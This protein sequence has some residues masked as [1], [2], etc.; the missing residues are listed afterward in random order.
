MIALYITLG[1][2]GFILLADV[3]VAWYFILKYLWRSR[4]FDERERILSYGEDYAEAS[5]MM[6]EGLDWL[7][8]QTLE[9]V[10]TTS[11]DGLRLYGY[12]LRA[13]VQSNKYAICVHGY[14]SSPRMDYGSSIRFL[15]DCGCNVLI[16]DNRSHGRS[17][18]HFCGFSYLDSRDCISWCQYI[19]S[20]FGADSKILLIGISMGGATVLAAS[21]DSKLPSCVRGVVSDCAFSSGWDEL[22]YQMKRQFNLP[23]FPILHTVDLMLRIFARYSLRKGTAAER[24]GNI[25][26]PLLIIHGRADN[27]VPTRM[28]SEI[29]EAASCDKRLLL[30]D[31]A[32]HGIS[33][34]VAPELYR[35]AIR[36]ILV[37]ADMTADEN[38]EEYSGGQKTTDQNFA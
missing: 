31:G 17:E 22:A 15:H 6:C 13:D 34:C 2:I 37:R 7:D 28:A 16:P 24:A 35:E 32:K 14:H 20:H 25:R 36:D 5:R 18:G 27:F 29:Y 1:V 12:L 10:H 30:V 9:D 3:A 19:E 4:P 38:K 11:H 21:G 23:T 26:V 8:T 33:Y